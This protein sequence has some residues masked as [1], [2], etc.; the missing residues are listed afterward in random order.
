MSKNKK[1]TILKEIEARCDRILQI[2]H[3]KRGVSGETPSPRL[4][5]ENDLNE[6]KH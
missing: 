3:E 4:E 6:Q 1:L 5:D 2:I